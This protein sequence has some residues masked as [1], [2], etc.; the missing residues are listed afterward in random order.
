MKPPIC[1]LDSS[2]GEMQPEPMYESD[3]ITVRQFG[4]FCSVP[5]CEGYGGPVG[6]VERKVKANEQMS[7]FAEAAE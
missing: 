3:G 4:W 5:G 1:D 7:L 2:H 6:K